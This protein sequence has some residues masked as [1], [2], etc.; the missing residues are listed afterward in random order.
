[1]TPRYIIALWLLALAGCASGQQSSLPYM[2]SPSAFRALHAT[3]A[4]KITHVIYVVQENRSFDNLFQGYPGADTVSQGMN[5]SGQTIT[6]QPSSLSR[7]YIIDHSAYAMFAACNGTGSLP[8]TNCKMNGFNNEERVRRSVQ[9]RNT[10]T[11]RT[12]SRS[13]TSTWRTNGW[14]ATRCSSRSSTRASLRIST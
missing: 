12:T 13:P 11:C 10:C 9:S 2:Q 7:V 3:G 4:G 14:S 5:S 8:G 6:L 1:M